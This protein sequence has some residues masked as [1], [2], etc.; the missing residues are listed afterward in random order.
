MKVYQVTK[1]QQ[2]KLRGI[3]GGYIFRREEEGKYYVNAS[4]SQQPTVDS[5][6]LTPNIKR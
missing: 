1:D 4:K 5:I 3:F 6:K 2:L